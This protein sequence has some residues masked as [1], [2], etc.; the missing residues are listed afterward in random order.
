MDKIKNINF[1]EP[2][3]QDYMWLTEYAQEAAQM[4]VRD[5]LKTHQLR[6]VFASVEKIRSLHRSGQS[7]KRDTELILLKPKIAYA[8]GRQRSVRYN[9]FPFMEV[10]IDEVVKHTE[11]NPQEADKAY[12]TFFS[13][14]ES[15]VAY[16]KFYEN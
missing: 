9:F 8:A 5:R 1:H 2:K 16:H 11:G 7:E 13:L 6:N 4:F 14:M 10:A 12:E 15:V 3:A